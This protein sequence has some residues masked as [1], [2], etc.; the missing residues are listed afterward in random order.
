LPAPPVEPPPKDSSPE[1][2]RSSRPELLHG[3]LREISSRRYESPAGLIYGPGSEHGH[4]LKHIEH[5]MQ[6][7][8]GRDIHGVFDGDMASVLRWIDD[9]YQ[10]GMRGAKGT[11]KRKEDGRDIIEATF[12]TPIG[13]VG[14]K[15]GRRK[16][17]PA[18]KRLRLVVQ[19]RSVITAFPF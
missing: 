5:H 9:A 2:G 18:T 3:L 16:G 14:G 4:R 11:T 15:S 13:F 1:T 19:E 8:V 6:D 10:R 7:N 17:N 12:N